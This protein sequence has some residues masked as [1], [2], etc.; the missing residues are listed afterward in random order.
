MRTRM[1]SSAWLALLLA[2]LSMIGPFSVD[3]YLPA[4]SSIANALDAS[5]L[6][7]QQTLTAYMASFALMI[8]WHGAL[9]DA[10][11][12]RSIIISPS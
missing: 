5:A 3:T 7:V 4:F 10:F 1:V 11:G 12:R 8:L 6:E 9:S 2:L